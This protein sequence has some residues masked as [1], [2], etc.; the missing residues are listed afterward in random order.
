MIEKCS[1]I[2]TYI[3]KRNPKYIIRKYLIRKNGE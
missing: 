3:M 2:E 1:E